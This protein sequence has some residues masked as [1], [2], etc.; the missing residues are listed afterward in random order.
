MKAEAWLSEWKTAGI[1]FPPRSRTMTTT[2]RLKNTAPPSNMGAALVFEKMDTFPEQHD[3]S[4]IGAFTIVL[5][6][7]TIGLWLATNRFWS[8]GERE[9]KLLAETSAAQS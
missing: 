7:S 5:A 6:V 3:K 2:L 1:G 9:L 4:V 8:A